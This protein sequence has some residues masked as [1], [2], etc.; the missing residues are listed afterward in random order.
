MCLA[1][2]KKGT[3]CK[4]SSVK[5]G[6]FCYIHRKQ[7]KAKDAPVICSATLKNGKPCKY[8]AKPG[9][10]KCGIHGPKK[11]NQG[12]GAQRSLGCIHFDHHQKTY[13]A[14]VTGSSQD[15]GN[16]KTFWITHAEGAE[17][18]QTCRFKDCERK[19][20][21]TGHMYIREEWEEGGGGGE[22]KY[23]YLVPICSHHNSVKYDAPNFSLM[24]K[25]T[26]AVKIL[27]NK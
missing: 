1:T 18:P 17:Y 27:E 13:M 4:F 11:D 20:T 19:A 15:T 8:K 14:N 12:T 2:T 26:I 10:D 25:T 23:N 24:K 22:K 16:W 7:A 9:S 6:G 21:C 3:K 5:Y